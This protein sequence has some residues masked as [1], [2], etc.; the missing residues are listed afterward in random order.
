MDWL[1]DIEGWTIELGDIA[2]LIVAG[3]GLILAY[4][5]IK[6]GRK[7]ADIAEKQDRMMQEQL[8]RRAVLKVR[9]TRPDSPQWDG[10]T[11]VIS[12]DN[13]GN[14]AARVFYWQLF[15]P[16]DQLGPLTFKWDRPNLLP[17]HISGPNQQGYYV[18]NSY[19]PTPIFPGSTGRIG[20]VIVNKA[21]LPQQIQ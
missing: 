7:Q 21:D 13:T 8:N 20:V 6:M 3:V 18:F 4:Y 10:K 15:I 5:A 9:F 16:D 19:H 1:P 17:R 11:V 12:V 14:K 2:N